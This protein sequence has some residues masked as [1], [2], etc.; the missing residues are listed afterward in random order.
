MQKSNGKRITTYCSIEKS[1]VT[2]TQNYIE[3]K[4]I[5]ESEEKLLVDR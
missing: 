5:Q 3:E 1:Y 2:H 4:A